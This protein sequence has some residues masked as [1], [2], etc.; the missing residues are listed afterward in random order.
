MV[1]SLSLIREFYIHK[2]LLNVPEPQSAFVEL[3]V[4]VSEYHSQLRQF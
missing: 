3:F 2:S 4:Q 1:A